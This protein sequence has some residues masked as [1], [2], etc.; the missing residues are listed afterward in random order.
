MPGTG[1][2]EGYRA[3]PFRGFGKGLDLKSKVDL[4]SEESAIDALNVTFTK[5]GAVSQRDGYA[6][7]SALTNQP[8]SMTA[9]TNAGTR[10]LVVG[11]GSRL[12]QLDTS[13][14]SVA[15]ASTSAAIHSF[16][17]YAAPGAED[18]YCANGTDEIRRLN[19]T[20]FTTPDY[21]DETNTD[22]APKAKFVT[23]WKDRLVSAEHSA[24]TGFSVTASSSTIR[25]SDPGDPTTWTQNN[26]V[27]LSPGDGEPIMGIISWRELL[28]VFKQT[29]FFVFNSIST[30]STGQPVFNYRPVDSQVGLAASRA[31]CSSRDGVYFLDRK[32]VYRTQGQDPQL[33]SEPIEPIFFGGASPFFQG[34][35]LLTSQITNCAMNWT[36]E[37]VYL[38]Y[39]STGTTNNYMAVY[40][41]RDDWWS[42]FDIPASAMATF[43]PSN[44]DELVFGAG[45]KKIG[46]YSLV[47][48]TYTADIAAAITSRWQ[49]GWYDYSNPNVKTIRET[50]I[51]AEGKFS[52]G[53]AND[54]QTS[55]QQTTALDFTVTQPLVGTAV[56]GTDVVGP[57]PSYKAKEVRIAIR[58]MVFSTR[59]ANSTLSQ[60]F[61][62]HRLDQHLRE[63]REE[64]VISA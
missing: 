3:V 1:K 23:T 12:D 39:T 19:G 22:V 45:S 29:K 6:V 8:D 38:A 47:V 41:T 57:I 43:R 50:R 20:T 2:Q 15:N 55:S 60:G 62:L 34:G 51:T 30:D 7:S 36:N 63:S 52:I 31:L 9:Y 26:Y 28:F 59:I 53:T 58:G 4:V 64:S 24:S 46:R 44:D 14:T 18:L 27:H 35:T 49:S 33:L 25:F 48:G 5:Q 42:L 11:N 10:Y 17:R 21:E 54:Y 37:R 56:V 32:G 13:L 16:A 61:T 40:D